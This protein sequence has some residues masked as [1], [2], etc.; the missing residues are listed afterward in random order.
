MAACACN[1]ETLRGAHDDID[2]VINDIR[3]VVDKPPS[4]GQKS[5]RREVFCRS[6]GVAVRCQLEAE[7]VVVGQVSVKRI[8]DPITVRVRECV[9]ALLRVDVA[10]CIGVARK[11]K[12]LSGE[13]FSKRLACE[14]FLDAFACC[15]WCAVILK[16]LS[17]L[18]CRRKARDV[19]AHPA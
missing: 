3:D 8:D 5:Q 10:L 1:R 9:A 14:H 16:A 13:M 11:V 4:D 19:V 7:K 2:T 6:C 18:E 17:R 12:P 15:I